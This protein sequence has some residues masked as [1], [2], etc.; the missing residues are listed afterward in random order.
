[1]QANP[2]IEQVQ[3]TRLIFVGLA[4]TIFAGVIAQRLYWYQIAEHDRFAALANDEHEQ[5]RPIVPKR[6][7][8][9]DTNGR[10][11]VL[12]VM[13]DAVYVH[14]TEMTNVEKTAS[15]LAE[16]LGMPKD[17]VRGRIN[18]ADRSWTLLA[19]RVPANA[20]ARVE[21]ERLPGV[22]LQ[23]LPAREYPEGSTASQILG[24]VGAE[25]RGLTGLELTLDVELA[26]KPGVVLTER[27]TTGGEITIARKA[28]IPAVSGADLVLTIDRYI[29]R[30]VEREL[31]R[32]IEANKATGGLIIVMEPNTGAILAAAS[33]PTYSLTGSGF[34]PAQ[35][36]LFKP[37]IA[38][39]TYEPGSVMKLITTAAALEE[40]VVTADTPYFDSGV[41]L[42]NG[43]PIRN[44]DGGAYGTVSVR[45]IVIHSLN[46]GMQWVAG[47]LGP[48]RFY[49]HLDAFG[50]GEPIGVR[51]N[52]EASGGFRRPS[53]PGWS[54]IDL[55]TNSY[56]QSISVTPL[57][58]ITAVAALGNNGVLMRPQLVR[59]IRGQDG[60]QTVEPEPVRAVVSPRTARTMLDIMVSTWSQPALAGNRIEGYTLAA[61]SG[62]ADIPGPGGY[63]SGKTYAS[64][65]GFG[66]IP[67]PRFV[68]LVRLDR[69]EAIY[70]GAVAAP[71]FR[72]VVSELL[73]YFQIPPR[74]G[75]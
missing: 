12:S 60:P 59:E 57:Q 18:E 8:L 38:T 15:F 61:K 68:V 54:R 40:G 55:A 23:R 2:G 50:F 19:A 33:S 34:D 66:P 56:G 67:N 27:D 25:G 52:G 30:V 26:G 47:A 43:V 46:T 22:E 9:L 41:A 31:A 69:P 65:V 4:F 35:S 64:Y 29:Q 17:E 49:E 37:S 28:L 13:Y 10:P 62:T 21:A 45:Q 71:V 39:D 32:A 3:R 51:L 44:W 74:S 48:D 58:M 42:V 7:S 63:S 24:F 6:G 72:G 75:R 73:T 14:R 1:V 20:A 53:T 70:G 16:A 36:A 11:L 5:R